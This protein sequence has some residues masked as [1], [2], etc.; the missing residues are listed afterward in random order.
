MQSVSFE[1][2]GIANAESAPTHK[3]CHSVEARAK[4]FK[5]NEATS[6]ISVNVN[7]IEDFLEFLRREIVGRNVNDLDL[8]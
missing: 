8:P 3:Q 7:C 1:R 6:R 2:D 5:G 4:V